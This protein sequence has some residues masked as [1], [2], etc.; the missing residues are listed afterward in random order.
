M[1]SSTPLDCYGLLE[2]PQS[3]VFL[4]YDAISLESHGI[5]LIT[6]LK[7]TSTAPF[8]VP[9]RRRHLNFFVRIN[10]LI[11]SKFDL[12]NSKSKLLIDN[13]FP[14]KMI[15]RDYFMIKKINKTVY[16][17]F[18]SCKIILNEKSTLSIF[19]VI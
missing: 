2:L 14:F 5:A 16:F 18:T 17:N 8:A 10:V 6:A 7:T 11:I 3:A 1:P 15:S 13:I 19:R 4:D 9:S 12:T